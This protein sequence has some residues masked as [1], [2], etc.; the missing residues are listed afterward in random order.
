VEGSFQPELPLVDRTTVRCRK[1]SIRTLLCCIVALTFLPTFAA[2][3]GHA[4]RTLLL[5][6]VNATGADS[7]DQQAF[8]TTLQSTGFHP[9]R[10]TSSQ[11]PSMPLDSNTLLVG[12]HAG[13]AVLKQGEVA[14]IVRSLRSGLSLVTDGESP[15]SKAIGIKLDYLAKVSN[16]RDRY[17]PDLNIYWSDTPSVH[18]IAGFPPLAPKAVYTDRATGR[19]LAIIMRIGKGRCLYLAP[20]F[21]PRSGRGY[22]RFPTLPDAIVKGL[23][24]SPLLY[25]RAADAYFDAG[26][27]T[28]QSSDS[29]AA[30]WKR[31]GIRTIHAAAWYTYQDPPYDYQALINACHSRGILVYAWLEWPYVGRGF[32][33]KYPEWRQ[34]NGL[35]QDAQFDFLYLMDLRNPACMNTALADLDSLLALDWDGVDVA[36]FTLTGAGKNGLAGPAR[37]D[38]FTGFTDYCRAEF[39]GEQGFDP[40]EFFDRRSSHYWQNDTSGLAAFYRYRIRVNIAT[41]HRLFVELDRMNRERK[42]SW[43]LLLTIVDNSFHPEFDNLLGFDMGRTL[44]LLREFDVTLQVEDPYLEWMRP[45]NRFVAVGEYYRKLLGGRPFIIDVNVVEMKPDRELDFSAWQPVGTEVYQFWR[46]ATSCNDR[47][48]FYCEA[49]LAQEDW[50]LMPYAM[51]A[52]AE[53]TPDSGGWKVDASRTVVLGDLGHN[54]GWLMDDQPW[55]AYYGSDVIIPSGRHRLRQTALKDDPRAVQLV[56]IT[57]ELIIAR[58]NGKECTVEYLSRPRCA[59]SFSRRP[60]RVLVDG[61]EAHIP[62]LV[63]DGTST[64]MAPPGRHT[65]VVWSL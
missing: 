3:A 17:R 2:F 34:K 65:I 49:S 36:E 32:W 38:W 55:S 52:D 42:K 39:K 4:S 37:P 29:L 18:C 7:L 19:C 56:S 60:V 14:A 33:D 40:L 16:V 43:E 24:R 61:V 20:L 64:L 50:E 6:N 63:S 5:W 12:P 51:A 58:S 47:A 31:W 26:Y 9:V 54:G 15:L 48:C 22:G 13:A 62:C 28:G 59:I 8:E 11:L 35:L 1:C 21:D 57:G 46:Y 53:A 10:L 30:C 44:D 27:R 41:Q 25:R 23:G 45:P